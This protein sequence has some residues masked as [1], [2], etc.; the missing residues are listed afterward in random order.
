MPRA[1]NQNRERQPVRRKSSRGFARYCAALLIGVIARPQTC[2]QTRGHDHF[3]FNLLIL[4]TF[5]Q[6]SGLYW[7]ASV[8]ECRQ[9]R[10]FPLS[11]PF[12][13]LLSQWVADLRKFEFV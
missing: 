1:F 7:V 5:M 10:L 3:V 11:L 6:I 12:A 4:R 13:L 8:T 2:R 9:I